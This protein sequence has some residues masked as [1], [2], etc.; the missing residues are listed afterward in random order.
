MQIK[1]KNTVFDVFENTKH[2]AVSYCDIYII[3]I[4]TDHINITVFYSIWLLPP[5]LDPKLVF[6]N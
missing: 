6:P 4:I 1:G 2:I 3:K 5:L